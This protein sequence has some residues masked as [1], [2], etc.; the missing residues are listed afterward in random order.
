M[1]SSATVTRLDSHLIIADLVRNL[2]HQLRTPVNHVVGFSEMLQEEAA[3]RCWDALLPDLDRIR[4]AGRGLA[5]YIGSTVDLAKLEAGALNA[6]QISRD[7]RTPL[8]SVIGY[9]QLLQEEAAD[10]GWTD[11][12]PDLEKVESAAKYLTTLITAVPDLTKVYG[13]QAASAPSAPRRRPAR[14]A[15]AQ[16][17][18]QQPVPKGSILVAD[19]NELDAE[20]MS[21]RLEQFGYRVSLARSGRETLERLHD[22]PFDLFMLDVLMPDM[23]GLETLRELKSRADTHDTPVLMISAVEEIPI[24]VRCVEMGA[25]DYLGKPVDTVLLRAKIEA[26]LERKRLRDR[27]LEYLGQVSVLTAAAAALE[28]HSFEAGTLAQ[29]AARED[30]LGRLARVFQRM[31]GEVE[32]RE[33]ALLL[34]L[35]ELR[36]G[37]AETAPGDAAA[38]AA[39]RRGSGRAPRLPGPRP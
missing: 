39:S 16:E 34:Q 25:D 19:D 35:R 28:A 37:T 15:A 22:E 31:A 14:P 4:Q 2:R 6:E 27:E 11:A 8:E 21:R 29:V 33:A 36:A 24:V 12:L 20:M 3:D 18:P 32:A 26:A 17:S 5:E 9:S 13:P 10:S 7:L 30:P 23:D 38:S 1:E